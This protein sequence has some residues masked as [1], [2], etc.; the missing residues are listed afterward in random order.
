MIYSP[1]RLGLCKQL[2]GRG[3]EKLSYCENSHYLK[4]SIFLKEI[5]FLLLMEFQWSFK[6][7]ALLLCVM[8][9]SL[10]EC[11]LGEVVGT[12]RMSRS[13]L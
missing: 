3:E 12:Q 2:L 7:T 6:R 11:L 13:E 9:S 5:Y 4:A 1:A 10:L 8:V